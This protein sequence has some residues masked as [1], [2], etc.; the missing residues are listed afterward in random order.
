MYI[1]RDIFREI[2]LSVKDMSPQVSTYLAK[3]VLKKCI[4]YRSLQDHSILV[5]FY[6]SPL[7]LFLSRLHLQPNNYVTYVRKINVVTQRKRID[8]RSCLL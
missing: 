7:S 3:Y 5:D 6:K 8:H 4:Y 2:S 1:I